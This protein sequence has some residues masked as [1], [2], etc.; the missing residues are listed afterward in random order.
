M[1]DEIRYL[2]LQAPTYNDRLAKIRSGFFLKDILDRAMTANDPTVNS[3]SMYMY[4][5]HGKTM[6]NLL[7]TMKMLPVRCTCPVRLYNISYY[8]KYF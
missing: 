8:G 2:M 4:S 5:A 6:A 3:N 7:H 1:F